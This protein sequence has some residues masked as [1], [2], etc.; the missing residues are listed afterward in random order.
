MAEY[1]QFYDNVLVA[2]ICKPCKDTNCKYC[3]SSNYGSSAGLCY[4]CKSGYAVDY[5]ATKACY[6]ISIANCKRFWFDS[7]NKTY[8]A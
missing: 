1:Y 3:Y 8:F 5:S 7:T 4:E 6:N 2:Y